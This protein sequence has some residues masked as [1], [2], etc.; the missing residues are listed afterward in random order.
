MPAIAL[1]LRDIAGTGLFSSEYIVASKKVGHLD[2]TLGMGWGILG[3]ASNI[4]N[5]LN[6]LHDG[7]RDRNSDFGEGGTFSFKNWFSG[8]TAIFG[9]LEY[10]LPK[11][12]LRL[13]LEYDTSNP[14]NKVLLMK[15]KNLIKFW[16]NFA[17]SNNLNFFFFF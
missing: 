17:F 7:F 1:D 2:L 14:D 3:T 8:K 15:L 11:R 16:N 9:G 13:K 10:D 12:G 4:S 6:S 5:P